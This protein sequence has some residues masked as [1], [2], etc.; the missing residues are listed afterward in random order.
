MPVLLDD[1]YQFTITGSYL[2]QDMVNV[3]DYQAT[4]IE[5]A[6][7]SLSEALDALRAMWV[8]EIL[9]LQHVSAR[10]IEYRLSHWDSVVG[11]T[12][13]TVRPVFDDE[14]ILAGTEADYGTLMGT[15]LPSNVAATVMKR[16]AGGAGSVDYFPV[17]PEPAVTTEKAFRGSTRIGAQVEES[18]KTPEG[19]FL[20]DAYLGL[21]QDA[22]EVVQNPILGTAPNRLTFYL[23]VASLVRNGTV[24][25]FAA[26][27][28]PV[29]A[30]KPVMASGY[31]ARAWVGS[32]NSRKYTGPG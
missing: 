19:N 18:T 30:F 2:G 4:V 12:P 5:G 3:L 1:Y 17:D 22:V 27:A 11:T 7:W 8:A 9:P 13:L 29:A 25:T 31:V 15:P 10:V 21:L 6:D 28:N 16:T 32:Q 14:A 26:G 20:T 24:R 23:N